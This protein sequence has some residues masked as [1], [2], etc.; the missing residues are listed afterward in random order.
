MVMLLLINLNIP[1]LAADKANIEEREMDN[2]DKLIIAHN[3]LSGKFD[4]DMWKGI[5]A[6]KG[7]TNLYDLD[8]NVIAYYVTFEP[9]GYA[10]VNNNLDNSIA[11]EFGDGNSQ[12]IEEVFKANVS[13]DTA[14]HVIYAG[15]GYSFVKEDIISKESK[16]TKEKM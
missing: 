15:M 8:D 1:V 12:V 4:I 2:L 16:I 11:I 7:I 5:E 6:V 13:K 14:K 10:I 3:Y 9:T